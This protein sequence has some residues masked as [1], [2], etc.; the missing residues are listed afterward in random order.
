MF[1]EI[2]KKTSFFIHELLEDP[3]SLDD[4]SSSTTILN[5]A[6]VLISTVGQHLSFTFFSHRHGSFAPPCS[7]TFTSAHT[8]VRLRG[9]LV[10]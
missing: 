7:P 10:A 9:C 3:F 4:G 8:L 5:E 6:Q 2:Q 1:F